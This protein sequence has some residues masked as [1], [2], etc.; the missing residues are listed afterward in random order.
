M[1]WDKNHGLRAQHLA[2]MKKD[3]G[4]HLRYLY[5]TALATLGIPSVHRR[6]MRKLR[7]I[8]NKHQIRLPR[9]MKRATCAGCSSVLVPVVNCT[10]RIERRESGLWLVTVCSCGQERA[11]VARGR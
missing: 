11:F 3:F 4:E 10:S 8:S 6:K 1:A 9:G 2:G 5:C 7:A